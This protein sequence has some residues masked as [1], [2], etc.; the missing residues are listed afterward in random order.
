MGGLGP[1]SNSA[2]FLI[3]FQTQQMHTLIRY[4]LFPIPERCNCETAFLVVERHSSYL[5]TV[6][7][8]HFWVVAHIAPK[9]LTWVAG[10]CILSELTSFPGPSYEFVSANFIRAYHDNIINVVGPCHQQKKRFVPYINLPIGGKYP[11]SSGMTTA[12]QCVL[13]AQPREGSGSS[14][15]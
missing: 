1:Q 12:A 8:I 10:S 7:R 5:F 6:C 13:E 3:N 2:D 4:I 15:G 11:E 14:R 9:I